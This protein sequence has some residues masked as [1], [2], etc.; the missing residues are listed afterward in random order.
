MEP[1]PFH[2]VVGVA[3]R[4]DLQLAAI[5]GAGIHLA[6]VQRATEESARSL[7]YLPRNDFDLGLQIL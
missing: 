2:V 5:A 4:A 3:E 1:E 7:V 6:D